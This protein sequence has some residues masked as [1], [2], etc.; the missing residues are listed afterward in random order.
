MGAGNF[1]QYGIVKL[2]ACIVNNGGFE[3]L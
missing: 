3:N 1:C 2:R